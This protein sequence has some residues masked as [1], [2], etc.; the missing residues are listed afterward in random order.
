ME[1]LWELFCVSGK[2]EDYLKYKAAEEKQKEK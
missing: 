2:I 1:E